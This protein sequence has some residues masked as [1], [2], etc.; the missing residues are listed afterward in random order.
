MPGLCLMCL[1]QRPAFKYRV[2]TSCPSLP[3]GLLVLLSHALVQAGK[4]NG[5]WRSRLRVL[6]QKCRQ[7]PQEALRPSGI[8]CTHVQPSQ[9]LAA[10][11]ASPHRTLS[12]GG[13]ILRSLNRT[14][15]ALNRQNSDF[16]SQFNYPPPMSVAVRS[17]KL[18]FKTMVWS[19]VHVYQLGSCKFGAFSMNMSSIGSVEEEFLR[20][21]RQKNLQAAMEIGAIGNHSFLTSRPPCQLH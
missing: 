4:F 15:Y 1:A 2:L 3:G 16:R 21:V 9:L 20:G 13:H 14:S 18:G 5:V 12:G 6:P 7:P 19:V 8:H 10:R 11:V 17:L